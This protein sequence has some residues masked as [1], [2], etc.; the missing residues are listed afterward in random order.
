M[1]AIR[2]ILVAIKDPGSRSPGLHKAIQL[3]RAFGARLELF[4]ALTWPIYATTDEEFDQ[5]RARDEAFALRRLQRLADRLA[6]RGR[7]R[8]LRVSV[9]VRW[10]HPVY[11]AIIRRAGTIKADLIVADR[12][13]A[14]H[15]APSL[16]HFNDW[17]LLRQSPVPVLLV[18]R[19]ARYDHPV[20]LA[21]VDPTHS[22]DKP[23]QLDGVILDASS[24]VAAALHGR[25]H[26]VHA[27]VPLTGGQRPYQAL[28]TETAATLNRRTLTLARHR[29]E[30][31]LNGYRISK[32]HRH[33]L[34]LPPADAIE[35]VAA[36]T[37]AD[38]VALG[39]VSRSGWQRLLIGN[40]AEELLDP[41]HSDLLVVKPPHFKARVPRRPTG[42]RFVASLSITP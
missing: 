3:A 17:E 29:Y 41:L 19:G 25:L 8:P 15:L 30:R 4:H 40:T 5:V 33:L 12:H 37:H 1:R 7:A 23:A 14:R 10:D 22:M 20:V 31:L 11:E 18:K 21:A 36:K 6:G 16:L 35:A 39:A 28:D 9:A 26:S 34:N 27:C 38:I 32:V 42:A 2:Q 24:A 13:H